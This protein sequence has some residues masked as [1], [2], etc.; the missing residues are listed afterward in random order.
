MTQNT[1]S[2]KGTNCWW[3]DQTYQVSFFL[4]SQICEMNYNREK[5]YLLSMILQA[6]ELGKICVVGDGRSAN[7]NILNYLIVFVFFSL[8]LSLLNWKCAIQGWIQDIFLKEGG[9]KLR[10]DRTLAP[11]GTGVSEGDVAPQKWRK[12]VIFKVNLHDLVHSFCLGREHKVPAPISAK[13]RGGAP[14]LNP[15]LPSA[16]ES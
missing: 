2:V 14:P 10:T 13:N 5:A 1:L 3:E 9:P 4:K 11:V 7:T 6:I 15:P 12:I 8:S 16:V